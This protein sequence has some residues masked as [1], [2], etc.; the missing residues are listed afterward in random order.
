MRGVKLI[1]TTLPKTKA[2][3]IKYKMMGEAKGMKILKNHKM[4]P[5]PTGHFVECAL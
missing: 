1:Y 5:D 3:F 2:D 4:S